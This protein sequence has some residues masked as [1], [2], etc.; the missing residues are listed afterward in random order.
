MKD[1]SQT[2][3]KNRFHDFTIELRV[4]G[5]EAVIRQVKHK[6]LFGSNI[7]GLTDLEGERLSTYRSRIQ[8]AWNAGTL[9]FYWGRY[10]SEEGKP[11]PEG[12]VLEAAKWAAVNGFEVK[13]HPLCWH[14][15]CADWLMNY[16][17][18]TILAKQLERITREVSTYKGVIDTWDVINETVIMPVFSKYD[19]AVTRIAK[20]FGTVELVLKCFKAAREA[21]PKAK[22][23]INDFDLSDDY[24]RNIEELLD[25]GC[26]IDAIGL[27]THMHEGYRGLANVDAYLER[28]ERFKLPLHFTE[29]TILSGKIAPKVDDLNDL[30]I[31][32][33]PSTGEGEARQR[34][35]IEEF[36]SQVYAHP[37]TEALVWWDMVDGGWLGAPA[38]LLRADLSRKDGFNRLVEL[39]KRDWWFGERKFLLS[40]GKTIQLRAPEGSYEAVIDGVAHPF[41]LEVGARKVVITPARNS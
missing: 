8:E 2:I 25:R 36:Y 12:K 5:G 19:N 7:F 13:G 4:N 29:A 34:E 10:E 3:R 6:F 39:I 22:L 16:D 38:G 37:L 17:D 20:R 1:Y 33:W 23:L 18:Q 15:I 35:E 31:D 9:P 32:T 21:N 40:E 41:T 28:F 14:T 27:Q 24:A 26:T 30:H 11:D